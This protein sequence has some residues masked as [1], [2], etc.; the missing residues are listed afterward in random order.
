MIAFPVFFYYNT[1][2][3]SLKTTESENTEGVWK[4]YLMRQGDLPFR[5]KR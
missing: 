1:F 5:M 3:K 4:K 2:K